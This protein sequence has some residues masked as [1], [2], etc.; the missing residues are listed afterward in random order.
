MAAARCVL[1]VALIGALVSAQVLRVPL[2]KHKTNASNSTRISEV[3]VDE[4]ALVSLARGYKDGF[5]SVQLDLSPEGRSWDPTG[6]FASQQVDSDV[7]LHNN[8]DV[9]TLAL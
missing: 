8:K 3:K 6:S 4:Q 5:I 7:L 1:T 2:K 9:S